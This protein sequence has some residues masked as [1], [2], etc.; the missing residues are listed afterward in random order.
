MNWF[1]VF[2][3]TEQ[4]SE[5]WDL[6]P[7]RIKQLCQNGEIEAV[8]IGNTWIIKKEQPNPKKYKREEDA[9]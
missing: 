7:E 2:M 1:D 6:S 3:G 5:L 9:N 4:A 8:K